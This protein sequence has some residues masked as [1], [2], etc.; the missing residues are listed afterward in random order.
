MIQGVNKVSI[1][2]S[3]ESIPKHENIKAVILRVLINESTEAVIVTDQIY[4]AYIND[5]ISFEEA[6]DTCYDLLNSQTAPPGFNV[7]MA[8]TI[9]SLVAR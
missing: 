9:K 4:D 2:V 6:L 1:T 8:A 3:E 5:K 7:E